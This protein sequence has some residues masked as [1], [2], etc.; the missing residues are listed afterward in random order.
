MQ[1]ACCPYRKVAGTTQKG[2]LA[3]TGTYV[4]AG[5]PTYFAFSQNGI[6]HVRQA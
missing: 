2:G 4:R 3:Q 5:H 6:L 1:M